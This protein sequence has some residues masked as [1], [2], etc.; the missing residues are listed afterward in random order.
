M[1]LNLSMVRRRDAGGY[2]TAA[3]QPTYSCGRLQILGSI[4][5]SCDDAY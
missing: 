2:L 5:A 1:F 3:F 4:F